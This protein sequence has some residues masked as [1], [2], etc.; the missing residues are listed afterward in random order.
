MECNY[1]RL[2]NSL[3]KNLQNKKRQKLILTVQK[4]GRFFDSVENTY[5]KHENFLYEVVVNGRQSNVLYGFPNACVDMVDKF[6]L[7][8]N[9]RLISISLVM[10]TSSFQTNASLVFPLL[11][12]FCLDAAVK[13]LRQNLKRRFSVCLLEIKAT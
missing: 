1:T 12:T 4:V 6:D 8:K 5:L 10:M 11:F 7:R 9:P 13:F 2:K 3:I